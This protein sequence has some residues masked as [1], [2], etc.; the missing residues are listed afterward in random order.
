M[1]L[2]WRGIDAGKA[3][4]SFRQTVSHIRKAQ[5]SDINIQIKT[6][7]GAI[8]AEVPRDWSVEAEIMGGLSEAGSFDQTSQILLEFL[9]QLE[10]VLGLSEEFDRWVDVVITGLVRR[11]QPVLTQ[12]FD[13]PQNTLSARAAELSLRLEPHYE[14]AVRCLMKHFWIHKSSGRAIDIYDAL[15]RLLSDAF[16]QE[17]ETE[18]IELLAAIKL[19]PGEAPT[20]L[21]KI[22]RGKIAINVVGTDTNTTDVAI[23]SFQKVL[24]A[25]LRDRLASFREWH[26]LDDETVE[27][28]EDAFEIKL[29]LASSVSGYVLD[30][31]LSEPGREHPVWSGAIKSPE[32]T[33]LDKVRALIVQIADALQVVVADRHRNDM[34]AALY[35]NWLQALALKSTWTHAD[36]KRAIAVFEDITTRVPNFGPAHAELAGIFN[37]QHVL[38]PG[39]FRSHSRVEQ[40]LA[41]AFEA[42]SID[43]RDTRAHR[44]LAWCHC[45]RG[46]FD[47]AEFHF[48]QSLML[49]PQNAHTMASAALGF[50]FTHDHPRAREQIENVTRL[51]DTMSPF[52]LIYLAASNYLTG[53]YVAAQRQCEAGAGLMSTVGGWH[54]AALAKMGRLDEARSRF[55]DYCLEISAKWYGDSPCTSEAV[56]DWFVACFP[57]RVEDD[58]N[59]LR[60][61]LKALNPPAAY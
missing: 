54:S 46:D 32:T 5:G 13:D 50:A 12:Y 2:L 21:A 3:S 48:D 43:P 31:T 18:T 38:R 6:G 57:L 45:H 14:P 61:T 19:S 37:I 25:D 35:D 58:R 16:D 52:H 1:D 15:Y 40:A 11:L 44:V 55:S 27:N 56:I 60:A 36:E 39:T 33:W 41:H 10:L 20:H 23:L 42:I 22:E 59:D 28:L 51:F 30:V 53:D 17:P 24:E 7:A 8:C 47:L 29:G 34:A 9:Q 26:V 49:N 4:S